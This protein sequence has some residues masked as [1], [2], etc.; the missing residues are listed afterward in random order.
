MDASEFQE[1]NITAFEIIRRTSSQDKR[2]RL[3]GHIA[4]FLLLNLRKL[5][6][7]EMQRNDLKLDD[8]CSIS[9]YTVG[10]NLVRMDI[11][12]PKEELLNETHKIR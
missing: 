6:E 3:I 8:T 1:L 2:G 12:L 5:I 7:G 9:L 10:N 11:K 4:A